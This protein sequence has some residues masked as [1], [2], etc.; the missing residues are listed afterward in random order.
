MDGSLWAAKV[1]E[2]I[3]GFT[4]GDSLADMGYK[5]NPSRANSCRRDTDNV[6][7]G[8]DSWAHRYFARAKVQ[9][10]GILRWDVAKLFLHIFPIQGINSVNEASRHRKP[11]AD[12]PA[13][14]LAAC[15]RSTAMLARLC[16]SI[17]SQPKALNS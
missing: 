3:V 13:L 7:A 14:W 12:V 11:R 9:F 17:L 2:P 4:E 16:W 10:A 1:W 6:I 5:N 15:P 8:S